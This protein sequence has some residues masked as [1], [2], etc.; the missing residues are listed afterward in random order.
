M[1]PIRTP[2]LTQ[3]D[4]SSSRARFTIGLAVVLVLSLGCGDGEVG[5]TEEIPLNSLAVILSGAN[6][7]RPTSYR[8]LYAIPDRAVIALDC[9]ARQSTES[10]ACTSAGFRIDRDQIVAGA[11]VLVKALGHRYKPLVFAEGAAS[12]SALTL[13]LEPLPSLDRTRDYATGYL[14]DPASAPGGSDVFTAL[15]V[16]APTELGTARSVKFYISDL[17]AAPRVYLQNTNL[18]PLHYDFAHT[19][20]GVAQ[21]PQQ[22]EQS[23]YH[24]TNRTAL[25]GTLVDYPALTLPSQGATSSLTQPIT[26]QFFPND[27]LSPELVERAYLLLEER[28]GF[29]ARS[30]VTRRLVYVPATAQ[31]EEEAAA[32]SALLARSEIL[33][34][35]QADLFQGV[36]QQLLNPGIAY[37]TLRAVTPEALSTGAFS[38]RDILVLSRLPNDLPLVGGTISEEMQTPLSH[39]NVAARARGTPNMALRSAGTDPRILPLLDQLV[40]FEV[41]AFGFSVAATTLAEAE[42]YWNS[43]AHERLVP[44]SDLTLTRLVPFEELHFDDWMRVGAKAANLGQLRQLLTDQAPKGFAVPFSAYHDFLTQNLVSSALC[45]VASAQCVQATSNAEACARATD[46]C[47][48]SAA[49]GDTYQGFLTALVNDSTVAADTRLRQSCLIQVQTLIRNGTVPSA[50]ATALDSTIEQTFGDGQV[51]LRSSTNTEDLPEFSGAGLY[52]SVSAKAKGDKAASKRIREVWAS[53]WSFDAFE[54][55]SY[56]N[57]DHLSVLMGIAVNGAVDDEIANGVLITQNLLTRGSP[58]YYLNIQAGEVS[59]TNPTNGATPEVLSVALDGG[60]PTIVRR[61]YSSLSPAQ[62]ILSDQELANLVLTAQRV[63]AH[64]APLYGKSESELV[65]DLEFKIVGGDRALLIK[66]ARPYKTK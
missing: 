22:F 34:R 60:S 26:L 35:K 17:D 55:R 63:V 54:E 40:R 37:G 23:T 21:T 53:V 28:L 44:Q 12:D 39:V 14:S 15:S 64:F 25:A 11:T 49:N 45:D 36:E 65:L 42:A 19:V 9:P 4:E 57:I 20:L 16:S 10:L 18:H 32:A 33:V 43:I 56:W 2:W 1:P 52:E 13:P 24:G 61:S 46:R 41:R 59:V 27:D 29:V 7:S 48:G 38:T 31:R 5:H 6:G 8:V 51:R 3:A 50:F 58:G 62:A 47:L 30:G 66:Q